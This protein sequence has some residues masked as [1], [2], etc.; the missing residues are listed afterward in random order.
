MSIKK[1]LGFGVLA[2]LGAAPLSAAIPATEVQ[3]LRALYDATGGGNWNNKTGWLGAAGTECSWAGVTCGTGNT[4]VVALN[5]A[6]NNLIGTLPAQLQS[7]TNLT[8]LYLGQNNLGTLPGSLG[9]VV[10]LQVLNLDN[11]GLTGPIPSQLGNLAN[12]KAL[13]LRWNSGLS[14]PIPATL[15]G[16][17]NAERIAIPGGALTGSIPSSLGNLSKLQELDLSSNKLSGPIPVELS[18]LASLQNLYLDGNPLGG[19][20]PAELGNLKKAAKIHLQYSGLTGSI[21][22]ALGALPSLVELDLSNNVLTGS[23]PKELGNLPALQTLY[24]NDNSLAGPIPGELGNAKALVTLFLYS[25]ALAG[26][27][28]AGLGSLA[29]LEALGL[30]NNQLEGSVPAEFA[31]LLS[32]VR[33]TVNSNKLTSINVAALSKLTKLEELSAA[34]N[35][36]SQPLVLDSLV[37]LT[38]LRIFDVSSCGLT[39]SIPAFLGSLAS[40][41]ELYLGNNAF[42]G[43]IPS[44][45]GLNRLRRLGLNDNLLTGAIPPDLGRLSALTSLSLQNNH[46]SGPLPVEL[47]GLSHLDYLDAHGNGLGGGIPREFGNLGALAELH[48]HENQL[49]G[50]IPP[51]LGNLA[52]LASL[53]MQD[54]Q[55][56]GGFPQSFGQ[57]SNLRNLD[58]SR[59]QIGGALPSEIGNIT[60]LESLSLSGNQFRSLPAEIG[61]LARLRYLI[62]DGNLIAGSVPRELG[63]LPDLQQLNLQANQLTGPIPSEL[64]ALKKLTRL[65]LNYNQLTGPIP[66]ALGGMSALEELGLEANQLSGP[67]PGAL[68]GLSSI[69]D[70]NLSKNAL[71][72][73]IPAEIGSLATLG[74]L[75]LGGNALSGA[76]PS[77]LPRLTNLYDGWG[78]DLTFNALHTDDAAVRE[79]VDKKG[80]SFDQTQTIAPPGVTAPI[81]STASVTLRWNPILYQDD[82]GGYD[83]LVSQ[84]GGSPTVGVR[85][86]TKKDSSA[87]VA[88]LK[89]GT[90]YTFSVRTVTFPNDRNFNTVTSEPSPGVTGSTTPAG[91]ITVTLAPAAV[92]MV[93]GTSVNMTATIAPAAAAS[94]VVTLSSSNTSVATVPASVTVPAGATTATFAVTGRSY[95]TAAV[96][97]V[98]PASTGGGSAAADVTVAGSACVQPN[99]PSFLSSTGGNAAVRAGNSVTLTWSSSVALDPGG[100][101]QVDSYSNGD[102]RTGLKQYRLDKPTLTIPTSTSQ[103]GALCFVVRAISSQGCASGDSSHLTVAVQPGPAAFVVAQSAPI[104]AATSLN[105]PPP[106]STVVFK[107]IGFTA[108]PLAFR[109]T[110]AFAAASP[111]SFPS[112]PPGGTVLVTL[113][114]D[115]L[116]TTGRALLQGGLCGVWNDGAEKTVCAAVTLTVFDKP[117][118]PGDAAKPRISGSSEI[119][120]ISPPGTTPPT[121]VVT[122]TNPSGR[123]VRIAPG[124]SPGGTWLF[125]AGDVLTAIGPGA[126]RDLTLSVDRSKRATADGA[127]PVSTYLFLTNVDG[128]DGDRAIVTVFDEEPPATVS[129]T[130]RPYLGADEYSLILGSSVYAP[131]SGGTIFVSDGWIRNKAPGAVT[132]DLYYTPSDTDGI[133][134]TQVKRATIT[135]QPYGTYRLSDFVRGL[136]GTSGSGSVEVRSSAIADLSVR[137]T[138]DALTVKNGTTVRYGAEIPTV[139]SR[140]GVGPTNFGGA[141]LFLPGLRGGAG[142]ASRTNVILTETSGRAA[143][144][145]LRLFQKDGTLLRETNVTVPPYSKTQVNGS[146][147]SLFPDGANVDGASLEVKPASGSGSVA[148]FAT[149]IDNASQGYTTRG[150]RFVTQVLSAASRRTQAASS[151]LVIP[152]AAHASGQ[153]N[154]FYTTAISVTNGVASDANLTLKY[155][156]NGQTVSSQPVTVPGRATANYPDVIATLF[157][158]ADNTAGMIFVE[159]DAAK[160]VVT[161]DTST[162]LDPTQPSFGLSPSTLSAYAPESSYALGDPQSGP[163]SSVVSHPALEESTRFRTNLILAEVQGSQTTV[164]VRLFPPGSGGVPLAEKSYTL[165]AFDR[166]QETNFMVKMAGTGEYVDYETTVEWV[167]GAGRVLAVATK[168]DNDPESKRADVYVL[169]PTGGLQGTIGF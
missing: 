6:G 20:I 162:L 39:G 95:G 52:A 3:A 63:S 92:R 145:A 124:I 86:G 154:S 148:A 60:L 75:W 93:S 7:L 110:M 53:S 5:L 104:A 122:V 131:G 17:A 130:N 167:S 160:V 62:L 64:G 87:T 155:V 50:A 118:S 107:N 29:K 137:T 15:G 11:A 146:N 48:L 14:G 161:S 125:V 129:G 141:S 49:A 30:G 144:V 111:A 109:S 46:L 82:A 113:T 27:I 74:G 135:L 97:G 9:S 128:P 159:G 12:L 4:T 112:V 81:A 42:S 67:F 119:H 106:P 18:R 1:A 19:S 26:S 2:C 156:V 114:Y 89:P 90:T 98:L 163:P 147:T 66:A 169:G 116:S 70:I 103:A 40:L 8:T 24:L 37:A 13:E 73:A 69:R 158:V 127:P 91:S 51:E 80:Y 72:G 123:A 76:L 83:V 55:L 10:S 168:I 41:E 23:I 152:T 153:N 56:T 166:V 94:V 68:G 88:N 151:R 36:L 58:L 121:Q 85:T 99:T 65:Y 84:G 28:P 136:F 157:G 21:P 32:L 126:S 31:G 44:L 22:A 120:F 117:P 134:N 132:A 59:N 105:V 47:S 16:L 77:T 139:H 25:N 43:T 61:K 115:P 164:R 57:L 54:N 35:P 101:Y 150:G 138:V 100:W 143:T 96:T 45:A 108:A 102:C 149:V 78:L 33:L 133:G 140:E 71:T 142:S 79:F 165:N 38:S 34:G